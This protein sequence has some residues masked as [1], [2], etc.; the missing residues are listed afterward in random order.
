[1]HPALSV[2]VFTSA[3][4]MGYGLL[5]LLAL[6]ATAGALPVTPGLGIAGFGL[7]L[8]LITAGLLAST[9]HLGNPQR[10][11]RAFSQW[12][13]SWLSREGVLAV[14]T[15][16]AALAFAAG[17]LLAGRADGAWAVAGVAAALLALCTL[18]STGQIYATLRTIPQWHNRWTV[19]NYL[20]LGLSSGAAALLALTALPGHGG[21]VVA[22]AALV[23]TVAA[24]ALKLAYWRH[25]A[26]HPGRYTIQQATGLGRYGPVRAL[27][28]PHTETNY[29]QQE[30]GF[31]VARR[32]ADKLRRIALAGAFAAPLL[33]SGA[34]L[35]APGTAAGVLAL[36][37]LPLVAAGVLTERWLFFAEA[38]HVVTVYYGAPRV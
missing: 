11:W 32:H 6:L 27:E 31:R 3:S 34:C 38:Q 7:S 4:G 33:A 26:R 21:R 36:L 18:Y 13:T 5:A 10:A 12:R 17:W 30:M 28:A 16:P 19:P 20:A 23:T 14:I 22:A 15:Y 1:M 9:F 37:A 24:L 29:L 2:I 35:L 8:A 25:L